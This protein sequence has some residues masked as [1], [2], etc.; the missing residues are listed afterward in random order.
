MHCLVQLK[1]IYLI[2]LPIAWRL[3]D[4]AYLMISMTLILV[5]SYLVFI[6]NIWPLL[7]YIAVECAMYHSL[8][9]PSL[10]SPPW[11][12]TPLCYLSR[13]WLLLISRSHQK[14]AQEPCC[15][16]AHMTG[17]MTCPQYSTVRQTSHSFSSRLRSI[18]L[19]PYAQGWSMHLFHI[20]WTHTADPWPIR[21]IVPCLQYI[22][23]ALA[24]T[25]SLAW[26]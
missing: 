16:S 1:W 15:P 20:P 8:G 17:V 5:C 9:L 24:C 22:R 23:S 12:V 7:M 21:A 3:T 2:A 18:S 25:I 11:Y 10:Y 6:L 19:G 13:S 14:E 26:I 4:L